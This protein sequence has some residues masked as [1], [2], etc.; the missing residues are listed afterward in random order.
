MDIKRTIVVNHLRPN[1]NRDLRTRFG[2]Q[3]ARLL[4]ADVHIDERI[5]H[6]KLDEDDTPATVYITLQRK[7]HTVKLKNDLNNHWSDGEMALKADAIRRKLGIT[8]DGPR[9]QYRSNLHWQN[10]IR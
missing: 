3:I 9:A 6:S 4:P 1:F 5:E 7:R 2:R 10:K 8:A